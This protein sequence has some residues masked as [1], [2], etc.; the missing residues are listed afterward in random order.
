MHRITW[1]NRLSLCL[2]ICSTLYCACVCKCMWVF[3][4][5]TW[6][7]HW[8]NRNVQ[9]F[10]SVCWLPDPPNLIGHCSSKQLLQH[11]RQEVTLEA[12]E[13]YQW[14][15][16]EE[17]AVCLHTPSHQLVWLKLNTVSSS[18]IGGWFIIWFIKKKKKRGRNFIHK[19]SDVLAWFCQA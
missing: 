8:E 10:T 3:P 16:N 17:V 18:S 5:R 12:M 7:V 14:G 9:A 15:M 13:I 11:Q 19:H 4:C 1:K 6:K 2:C